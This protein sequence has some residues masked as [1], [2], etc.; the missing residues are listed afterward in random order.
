MSINKRKDN[1]GK[2]NSIRLK[3]IQSSRAKNYSILTTGNIYYNDARS[4]YLLTDIIEMEGW[5]ILHW[6]DIG[7]NK[8]SKAHSK[9]D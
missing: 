3:T 8:F 5:R 7:D 4:C 1:G 9:R 6:Y 2:K